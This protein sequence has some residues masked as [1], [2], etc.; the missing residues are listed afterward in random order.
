MRQ[1]LVAARAA[2]LGIAP[3][4]FN[5]LAPGSTYYAFDGPTNTY[6]AA[7]AMDVPTGNAPVGSDLYK[8]QVASQD[9]GAY[10]LFSQPAGSSTWTVYQDGAVGPNTP[11]AVTV[12]ASVV[13]VWG[14]PAGSCRAPGH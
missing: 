14:W 3:S 7:A 6:W 4:T 9:D 1:S 10:L 8:A 12:P 5:G 2:Q 13:A 11:C